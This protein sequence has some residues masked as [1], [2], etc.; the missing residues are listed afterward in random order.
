MNTV[1]EYM[2]TWFPDIFVRNIAYFSIYKLYWPAS[3]TVASTYVHIWVDS[4][5]YFSYSAHYK[6]LVC[7]YVMYIHVHVQYDQENGHNH[8]HNH[9]DSP[10]IPS[11]CNIATVLPYLLSSLQL[12]LK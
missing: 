10:P 6:H 4:S 11:P 7:T 12:L 9:N 2:N 1:H 3:L 5:R 8:N